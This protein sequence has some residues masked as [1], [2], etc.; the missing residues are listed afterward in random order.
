MGSTAHARIG[1]RAQKVQE[2]LALF[3]GNRDTAIHGPAS[4][5]GTLLAPQFLSRAFLFRNPSYSCFAL[6]ILCGAI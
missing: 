1:C 4:G 3:D 2:D 6:R 5:F